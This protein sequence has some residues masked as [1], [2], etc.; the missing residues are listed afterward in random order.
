MPAIQV[1]LGD[2]GSSRIRR[3]ARVAPSVAP[4]AVAPVS[5]IRRAG[6]GEVIHRAIAA[7]T[8]AN[9]M[10]PN[11]A[12]AVMA[13]LTRDADQ[14]VVAVRKLANGTVESNVAGA[15][16]AAIPSI[17][18]F[19]AAHTWD[20]RFVR[21]KGG[22]T[23]DTIDF[24]PQPLASN[25]P[26]MGVVG[27]DV[28]S[29]AADQHSLV[30]LSTKTY[31]HTAGGKKKPVTK[32]HRGDH[33]LTVENAHLL[34][35][36]EITSTKT[37]SGVDKRT[38][39]KPGIEAELLKRGM[40]N[41]DNLNF[42]P[43]RA[44]QGPTDL[45]TATLPHDRLAEAEHPEATTIDDRLSL[46]HYLTFIQTALDSVAGVPPVYGAKILST[47][48]EMQNLTGWNPAEMFLRSGMGDDRHLV[49]AVMAMQTRGMVT[50]LVLPAPMIAT[51]SRYCTNTADLPMTV[52]V[53]PLTEWV[54]RGALA[55][56]G[57]PYNMLERQYVDAHIADTIGA[58]KTFIGA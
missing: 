2:V 37:S 46:Q 22:A 18:A 54:A 4:A 40:N 30:H 11:L 3:A 24:A 58:I 48:R 57:V 15:G 6:S 50:G 56:N 47:A 29:Q 36:D 39:N 23:N 10:L 53:T 20:T 8:W 52:P 44:Q 26:A 43:R 19:L 13:R 38:M 31:K 32:G 7:P 9:E 28:Q 35:M 16:W 51:L 14:V 21:A 25:I 5:R 12:L 41:V 45:S 34:L 33:H 55:G 49:R 42:Y 1:E 27:L 17:P